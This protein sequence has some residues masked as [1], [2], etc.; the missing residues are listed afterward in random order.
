[1]R[2]AVAGAAA[3]AA[4]ILLA[5]A[6][7]ATACPRTSLGDVE[8]EVMCLECGVPQTGHITSSS[9][10]PRLVCGHDLAS[11]AAGVTASSSSASASA[12]LTC[13]P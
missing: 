2:R 6:T 5:L 3:V 12:L 11:A 7:Q 10:S 4:C 13:A 1:M 8:D 9:T